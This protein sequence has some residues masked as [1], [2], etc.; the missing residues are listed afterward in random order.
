MHEIEDDELISYKKVQSASNGQNKRYTIENQDGVKRIKVYSPADTE[1]KTFKLV[2]TLKDVCVK[3]NDVGELYY[4][5][6]GGGW[7]KTL[8]R[9]NIDI[10]L[11]NNQ[12]EKS[13]KIFG[14]GPYQGT[15]SIISKNHIKLNVTNVKPGQYVAARVVFDLSNISSASK[16][17]NS[18]ALL[19]IMNEEQAIYERK[20][21]KENYTKKVYIFA[22]ILLIYWIIL[23]FLFEKD[24]KYTTT[25]VD[26][27][28]LMNKYNPLLAG[29]IKESRTILARDLIKCNIKSNK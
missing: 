15:A 17:S 26:D 27:M 5:F 19:Q 6:V 4:N 7:E 2:Y 11:P 24:K 29:C 16:S 22:L 18:E 13:L 12:D 8:K 20:E 14:H 23:L 9:V 3:H 1:S 28:E 21:Q 25:A 10:Y